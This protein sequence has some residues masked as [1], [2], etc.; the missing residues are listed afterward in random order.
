MEI[1]GGR[2]GAKQDTEV[3]DEIKLKGEGGVPVM[4][5]DSPGDKTAERHV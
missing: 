1:G 3:A 4:M 5:I 2:G